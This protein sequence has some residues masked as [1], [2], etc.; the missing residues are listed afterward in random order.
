MSIDRVIDEEYEK[1]SAL[2]T[3]K[4]EWIPEAGWVRLRLRYLVKLDGVVLAR[5]PTMTVARRLARVFS[6][7]AE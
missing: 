3:R 7:L 4:T 6:G 1:K 2:Y 5:C